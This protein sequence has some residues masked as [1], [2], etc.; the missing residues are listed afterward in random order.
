MVE[1]AQNQTFLFFTF[2]SDYGIMFKGREKI[3]TLILIFC[4]SYLF[5]GIMNIELFLKGER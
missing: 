2:A 1:N 3:N 5:C 4:A